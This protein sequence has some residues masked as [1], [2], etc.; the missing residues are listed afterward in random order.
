MRVDINFF[1]ENISLIRIKWYKKSKKVGNRYKQIG[2]SVGENVIK[3]ISYQIINQN[4]LN[5]ESKREIIGNL[6]SL[7]YC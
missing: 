3:E 1:F 2:N 7:K 4:L 5:D 6:Q